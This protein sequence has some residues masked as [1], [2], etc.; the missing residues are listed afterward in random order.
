[1]GSQKEKITLQSEIRF[2]YKASK[3]TNYFPSDYK[4]FQKICILNSSNFVLKTNFPKKQPENSI[5]YCTLEKQNVSA[6]TLE[7]HCYQHGGLPIT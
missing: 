6:C 5:M 1:M 7:M 4:D 3:T 2:L